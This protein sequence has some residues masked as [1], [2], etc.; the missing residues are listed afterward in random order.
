M[1]TA[2]GPPAPLPSLSPPAAEPPPPPP[3]FAVALLA[4]S[5]ESMLFLFVEHPYDIGDWVEIDGALYE[6]I[7]ITLMHT[8]FE[9]NGRVPALFPNFSLLPKVRCSPIQH[10]LGTCADCPLG[11]GIGRV[12]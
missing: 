6:V 9:A 2:T 3:C 10:A 5:F 11:L 8:H 12:R 7:K 4:R 1:C